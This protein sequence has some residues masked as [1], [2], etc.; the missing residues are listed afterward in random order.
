[1]QLTEEAGR[2]TVLDPP[3][4]TPTIPAAPTTTRRTIEDTRALILANAAV[5]KP[6]SK[7]NE[8]VELIIGK[9]RNAADVLA[10]S[11]RTRSFTSQLSN[12]TI[13][14]SDGPA[15][16]SSSNTS[17]ERR[18]SENG[19]ARTKGSHYAVLVYRTGIGGPQGINI[20]VKGEPQDTVEEAL[21]WMLDKTEI[22]VTDML[23]KRWPDIGER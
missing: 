16:A 3:A 4:Y 10:A 21:E 23:S 6:R 19:G 11:Q 15:A 12:V 18:D 5:L 13:R 20:L 7:T 8:Q 22:E 17:P 9:T 14:I 2:T 1:M